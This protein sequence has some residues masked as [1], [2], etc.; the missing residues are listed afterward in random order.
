MSH[1]M[2]SSRQHMHGESADELD[3]RQ[4]HD[5]VFEIGLSL[6]GCLSE[7]QGDSFA[8]EADDAGVADCD[9]VCIAGQVFE[10]SL[11]CLERWL[12]V[13]VPIL[14]T[15][16][17]KQTVESVLGL[18]R[19]KGSGKDKL[20]LSIGVTEL[21]EEAISEKLRPPRRKISAM[22]GLALPTRVRQRYDWP[23][24]RDC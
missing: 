22:A 1:A 24:G 10:Y 4:F 6:A 14:R 3:S 8:I 13:D 16:F 20:V 15:S 19:S 18:K 2:E 17:V 21:F 23:G 5:A 11:G 12:C 7:A 9:S